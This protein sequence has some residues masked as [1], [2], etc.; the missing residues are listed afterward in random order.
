MWISL[1]LAIQEMEAGGLK[2]K[3][4][5]VKSKDHDDTHFR[6]SHRPS[7]KIE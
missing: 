1:L 4:L 2:E 6:K 5:K 7:S 3:S